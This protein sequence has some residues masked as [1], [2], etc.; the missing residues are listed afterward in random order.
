[1]TAVSLAAVRSGWGVTISSDGTLMLLTS[2]SCLALFKF[3]M[4]VIACSQL[5]EASAILHRKERS[6]YEKT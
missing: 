5:K 4:S 1:M 3:L 6:G 2:M